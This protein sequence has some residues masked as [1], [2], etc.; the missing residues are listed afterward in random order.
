[1]HGFFAFDHLITPTLVKYLFLAGC[2]VALLE[3]IACAG[4]GNSMW[5]FW[6][7]IFPVSL[8]LGCEGIVV[9]YKIHEA[10]EDIRI[11]KTKP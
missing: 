1:M 11:D 9:I 2:I 8:R 3:G 10:L 5:A 6:F 4:H 7:I